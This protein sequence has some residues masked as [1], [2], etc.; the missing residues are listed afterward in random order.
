MQSNNME[1]M[2]QEL[3]NNTE[4]LSGFKWY[5]I[6][7]LA[8]F[9]ILFGIVALQFVTRYLLN[10]SVAWT[11]EI[12]RYF[13]II[14]GFVGAIG[15][16]RKY[17]HIFLEFFYRYLPKKSIK[18]IVITVEAI[19]GG[20]FGFCGWLCIELAERTHQNMVSINLP[21]SIIYYIVMVA[22]FMMALFAL[23]NIVRYWKLSAEQVYEEKLAPK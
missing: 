6:P 10:D 7:S 19:T 14:L 13:L 23:T 22:C 8:I 4:D 17:K 12:A 21:K 2:V 1:N 18:P 3:D 15:C 9:W 16:T 11:E 5:D 20:F